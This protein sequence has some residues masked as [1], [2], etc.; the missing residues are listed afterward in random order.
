MKIDRSSI[1]CVT[2][3]MITTVFS[4]LFG[5]KLDFRYTSHHMKRLYS[6]NVIW[7]IKKKFVTFVREYTLF[8][9]SGKNC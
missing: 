3:Y 4:L 5:E 7:E 8:M 1:A 9:I 2:D 6:L